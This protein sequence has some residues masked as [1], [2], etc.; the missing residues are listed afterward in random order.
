MIKSAQTVCY[1]IMAEARRV[2]SDV[3]S[4][5]E[6]ILRV[7]PEVAKTLRGT[8]RDILAEIEAYLGGIR[9]APSNL[10]VSPFSIWFSTMWRASAANSSGLPRRLGKGIA[11]P[12]C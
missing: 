4:H 12:S 7:N 10:I 6:V 9:S 3:D 5:N 8:E 11:A 2:S 1:E